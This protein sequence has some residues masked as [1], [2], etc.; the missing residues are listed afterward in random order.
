MCRYARCSVIRHGIHCAPSGLAN[1]EEY[2][3]AIQKGWSWAEIIIFFVETLKVPSLVPK[4]NLTDVMVFSWL[5]VEVFS[6]G[7]FTNG[8]FKRLCSV[9]KIVLFPLRFIFQVFLLTFLHSVMFLWELPWSFPK[10]KEISVPVGNLEYQFIS[11][12]ISS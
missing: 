2:H 1:C 10:W 9:S 4:I 6:N 5:P 3:I 7:S 12:K 11:V 8:R